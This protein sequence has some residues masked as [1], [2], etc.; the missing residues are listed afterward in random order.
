[1]ERISRKRQYLGRRRSNSCPR[2]HQ[3]LSQRK[4]S[5]EHKRTTPLASKSP[6]PNLAI[7]QISLAPLPTNPT[8]PAD[9]KDSVQF[10]KSLFRSSSY[11]SHKYVLTPCSNHQSSIY[12]ASI[13]HNDLAHIPDR[14]QCRQQGLSI[15]QTFRP[16]NLRFPFQFLAQQLQSRR[17]CRLGRH[18]QSSPPTTT[19]T[20]SSFAPSRTD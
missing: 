13:D 18:R 17:Q 15:C 12:G 6:S 16:P 9:Y 20:Q 1:M 3:T 7:I 5:P 19:S 4:P 11:S 2:P 14:P 8:L 10:F